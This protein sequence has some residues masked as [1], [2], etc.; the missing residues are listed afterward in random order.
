M[1]CTVRYI[2]ID[3]LI[4]EV[5]EETTLPHLLSGRRSIFTCMRKSVSDDELSYLV[6][7]A[8]QWAMELETVKNMPE[9]ER[10][11]FLKKVKVLLEPNRGIKKIQDLAEK[12]LGTRADP[13][14]Q[15]L[16]T[17]ER[18]LFPPSPQPLEE[19]IDRTKKL[20]NDP[21][22]PEYLFSLN[23][24]TFLELM[25]WLNDQPNDL[26]SVFARYAK[27]RKNEIS[28]IIKSESNIL[29]IDSFRNRLQ[30]FADDEEASINVIL[31]KN[32][33]QGL[34]QSDFDKINTLVKRIQ[35]FSTG[36]STFNKF[37]ITL[38][39]IEK[40][41]GTHLLM[42]ELVLRYQILLRR[43]SYEPRDWFIY[44]RCIYKSIFSHVYKCNPREAEIVYQG[45][46][47]LIKPWKLNDE[48]QKKMQDNGL[49]TL[50]DLWER[51]IWSVTELENYLS[52]S[53]CEE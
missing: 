32:Y 9:T 46:E 14:L 49:K 33:R 24:S 25:C 34:S 48:L 11:N 51:R 7:C 41:P 30:Y 13:L 53:S 36:Q 52:K 39:P 44:T 23:I 19:V 47:T 28:K 37:L 38:L 3:D 26:H 35:R 45:I 31:R 16:K 18:L 15:E 22:L 27:E 21:K 17:C 8:K 4:H 50:G 5:N 40:A 10:E 6:E 1:N 42:S 12:E 43:L 2:S 29:G 20:W